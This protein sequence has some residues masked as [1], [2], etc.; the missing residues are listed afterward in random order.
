MPHDGLVLLDAVTFME[1]KNKK[2]LRR[3]AVAEFL[4]LGLFFSVV[5]MILYIK[6]YL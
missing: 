4:L 2:R 3:M 5:L 6:L 1:H